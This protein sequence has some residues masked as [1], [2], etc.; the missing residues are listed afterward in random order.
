MARLDEWHRRGNGGLMAEG[1]S[2]SHE[3]PLVPRVVPTAEGPIFETAVTHVLQPA[4]DRLQHDDSNIAYLLNDRS[5]TFAQVGRRAAATLQHLRR[6]HVRRGDI[7]G[8]AG[9]PS[10]EWVG[11]AIGVLASGALLAPLNHSLTPFEFRRLTRGAGIERILAA[12]GCPVSG[13]GIDRIPDPLQSAIGLEVNGGGDE[14]AVVLHTSGST[15]VPKGVVLTHT[16]LVQGVLSFIDCLGC[17]SADRTCIAVPL[18]NVTGLVDQFLH[19]IWLG[20]SCRLLPEYHTDLMLESLV[21]DDVT[22]LIGVPTLFSLI[23][24]RYHGRPLALRIALYGGAP[25]SVPTVE[26]L[27]RLLPNLRP[28]QGYGMTEMT[29]LATALP[30]E[31]ALSHPSSVGLPSPITQLRVIADD[32]HETGRGELGEILMRGPHRTPGYWRNPQLTATMIDPDGWLHSGD[33]AWRDERGLIFLAGRRTSLINRGGEKI[34]PR[35]IENALCQVPGVLEAVAFSMPDPV[36]NEVPA[37]VVTQLP[38]W[39][40]SDSDLRRVMNQ[41]LAPYKQPINVLKL[42]GLPLAASGKPDIPALR[43]L[44]GEQRSN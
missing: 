41:R 4:L 7:I 35:E 2:R 30:M 17:T 8:L 10:E 14:P 13:L 21:E 11:A 22:M 42:S 5:I 37:A 38:G 20:G 28:L 32:G 29:S 1:L 3:S 40:V 19:M 12:P 15:G 6:S 23:V 43:A 33:I 25:M 16:N 34:S 27:T 26:G 31:Y 24:R 18:F 44:I 39:E 36:L 9:E